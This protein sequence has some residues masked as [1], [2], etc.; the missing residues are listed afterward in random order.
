VQGPVVKEKSLKTAILFLVFNRLDPTRKSFEA[1]RQARP[2]RL[3]I[4]SDGARP[5][6]EGEQEKVDAVRNYILNNI[7]WD[8]E[9][10]TLFREKNLGCRNAVSSAIEWFFENEEEGIILEDDCLAEPS[11]FKYCSELLERYRNEP[12]VMCISGNVY[13]SSRKVGNLSYYFSHIQHTW[14]WASWRRAWRLYDIDIKSF[15]EF[16]K[17][18]KIAQFFKKPEEQQYWLY[19]FSGIFEGENTTCW[20]YQWQFAFFNY[21]GMACT[22]KKNL[23]ENIGLGDDATHTAGWPDQPSA[24]PLTFPMTHP[25]KIDVLSD[26]DSLTMKVRFIPRSLPYRAI[27]KGFRIL[28]KLGKKL[29]H[30][31]K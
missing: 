12:R 3:Y 16:K 4:G 14:G 28:W 26:I 7:D 10:R 5:E 17:K 21:K 27:R 19:I 30:F 29:I 6:R 31:N 20:D 15:P 8:C 9:V 22:P 24:K 13:H 18:N 2:E 11:F 1:I 25:E 23:V